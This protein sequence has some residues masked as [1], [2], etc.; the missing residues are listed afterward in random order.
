MKNYG[1]PLSNCN[2]NVENKEDTINS[3]DETPLPEVS[4]LPQVNLYNS[5]RERYTRIYCLSLKSVQHSKFML[6]RSH[7]AMLV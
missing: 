3:S 6:S 2:D 7:L 4:T 1:D 5:L